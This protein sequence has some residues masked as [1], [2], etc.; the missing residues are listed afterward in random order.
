MKQRNEYLMEIA[1]TSRQPE[2]MRATPK[3]GL[4]A[5]AGSC[6]LALLFVA[7]LG[8]VAYGRLT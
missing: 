1:P 8:Y 7:S 3:A 4:A 6:I 2:E 5:W